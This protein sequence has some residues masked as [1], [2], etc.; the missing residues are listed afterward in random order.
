MIGALLVGIGFG[1]S[2]GV[3][4]GPLHTVIMTTSLQR[5]FAAGSRIAVAPLLTDAPPPS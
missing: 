2:G 3:A 1:F 4:P 5:G